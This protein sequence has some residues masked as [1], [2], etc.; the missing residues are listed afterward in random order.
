MFGQLLLVENDRLCAFHYSIQLDLFSMVLW[1][2]FG[3]LFDFLCLFFLSNVILVLMQVDVHLFKMPFVLFQW[4]GMNAL[5]VYILAA[6]ELFPAF[7]QGF[8]WRSPE[9][10]LV[11]L[12]CYSYRCWWM[13]EIRLYVQ[14]SYS[15]LMTMVAICYYQLY[16]ILV[17]LLRTLIVV[18][19]FV[20]TSHPVKSLKLKFDWNLFCFA[21][22]C[23][24]RPY[25]KIQLICR[26]F[27]LILWDW[28]KIIIFC[29]WIW[30]REYS[31]PAST[32]RGGVL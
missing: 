3:V 11:F 15:S 19:S 1:Y 16:F 21:D 7:I 24:I 20:Y 17:F 29:R 4:M 13:K 2:W 6:A 30:Q 23:F 28:I 22:L 5:I 10:N 12:F 9:N 8:Y 18:I 31:K 26:M 14:P 27:G 32:Q 25:H